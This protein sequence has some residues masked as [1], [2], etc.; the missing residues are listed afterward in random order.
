MESRDVLAVFNRGIVSKYAQARVDVSRVALSASLQSNWVSW[1]LGPMSIRPGLRY[2]GASADDGAYLPFIFDNDDVA[3][4]DLTPSEL[5]VWDDGTDLVAR[6]SV[7]ATIANGTFTSDL[8]S[9]T[10]DDDSGAAST[11]LTG[12]YMQLLGDGANEARRYQAVSITE[13][14]TVHGLR[15]SINQG[16]A[17]LRIGST[18]GDDDIFGQAVLRAG[19]HSIAFD[20]DGN[21]TVYITFASPL[22]FP[23][24]VDSV[25]IE[26][27][28]AMVLTTP[29]T[30]ATA[31]RAVRMSQ[32][33]DVIFC[34]S[35][36]T[37]RPYRIERRENNSWSLVEYRS[38]DGPFLAENLDTITLTPS[39][40][41]GSITLTAS[42]GV[43]QAG[44]VGSLWEVKSEGQRVEGSF[45]AAN[46]FTDPIRVTGVDGGRI[47]ELSISGTWAG[48]LTL[49]RSVGDVGNWVDVNTYT[50][51][52]TASID[53]GFDN[54]IIFYRLGFKA[55]EYTSGTAVVS[56]DYA[57][58][59]ITGTVQITAVASAT[60]ATGIVRKALGGTDATSFWSEAAWSD[61]QGWPEAVAVA[62]GRLCWL[63][64]GRFYGS[65]SDNFTSFD[66]EDV[67]DARRI[68]RRIGEGPVNR[69]NWLLALK[70]M[71]AGGDS[72]EHSI[73]SNSFDE[74]IT[75]DNY[76]SKRNSTKG[77]A[78]VPAVDV[79]G[80]GYFVGKDT[81]T[82]YELSSPDSYEFS[83][84]QMTVLVP[85]I[86]Q[87]GF[88]RLSVQMQPDVRMFGVLADGTAAVML[89]DAQEDILCWF[90]V[91]S[92]GASG[93]IV[94]VVTLPGTIEDRVFF[95]VM[96][97]VDGADVYYLE[98]MARMDQCRGAADSRIADSHVIK[99]GSFST[100]DGLDH[101]EG[102]EVVVWADG[103][104]KGTFTV[105][106]GQIDLGETVAQACAGLGY[107]A[108]WKSAKLAGQTNMGIALSQRERVN[109]VSLLLADTHYQGVT[110]GEDFDNMDSL[111]L[112]VDGVETAEHTIWDTLD[113]DM[114]EFPGDW[115]T[116][117]RLCLQAA[118]PRPATVMA[119]VAHIDRQD[120]N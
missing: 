10:D 49:Q 50:A 119:L 89:R 92:T 82:I 59:S 63:A 97:T 15:I 33:A 60:S 58:G 21:S 108:Q 68:D 19:T 30:T 66:P 120:A 54:S 56:L 88:T 18:A 96:R 72:A 103:E 27:A 3:L 64:N 110:F 80:R 36:K 76:N 52:A 25:A 83:A 28:G 67:G 37:I 47:F 43:F 53:D 62:E 116:D 1:K 90:T 71:I 77:S 46:T 98:E 104:D 41:T 40:L 6:S 45:S 8:A 22:D 42:R 17:Y 23:V 55:G 78:R 61:V 84:D 87:V 99:S 109:K 9:W 117:P 101:L 112:I 95:R 26:A 5:R 34:A 12:G 113:A 105:A 107:T 91:A 106:S 35:G 85:E 73:R 70:R 48:T 100:F 31:C 79:D 24:L 94:D 102:E 11:W 115:D 29:W 4:I 2:R 20:P 114:T 57:G 14:G 111:P 81:R 93:Q 7:S 65:A 32:S 86:G 13:T 39:A 69:M 44:H 75:Q 51:N 38:S 74:P 118:A 16:E